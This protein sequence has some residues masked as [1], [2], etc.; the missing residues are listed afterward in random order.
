MNLKCLING[1]TYQK[2]REI[3]IGNFKDEMM[4]SN[5]NTSIQYS[6]YD[7]YQCSRCLKEKRILNGKSEIR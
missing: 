4:A 1:H 7:V 6:G 3:E 5:Y 2:V